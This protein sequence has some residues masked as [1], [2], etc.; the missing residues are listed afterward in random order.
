MT[1]P[2]K[3]KIERRP[4]RWTSLYDQPILSQPKRGIAG[5]LLMALHDEGKLPKPDGPLFP[6][7]PV[8]H[9]PERAWFLGPWED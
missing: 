2:K 7:P 4:F 1:E 9:D 3:F 5:T 6:D 8:E